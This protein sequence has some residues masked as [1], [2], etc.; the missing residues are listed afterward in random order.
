[1]NEVMSKSRAKRVRSQGAKRVLPL[2]VMSDT[3]TH[4]ILPGSA[5]V[6]DYDFTVGRVALD[7]EGNKYDA[8]NLRRFVERARVAWD[9]HVTNYPTISRVWVQSHEVV[10]VG[11]YDPLHERVN[12]NPLDLPKFE[13]W[14][15]MSP[16]PE[17]ELVL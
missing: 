10:I 12:I 1:M 6:G 13:A 5:I 9:R 11:E 16:V 15:G 4:T 7:F 14:L 2:Y 3:S 17:S 8:E